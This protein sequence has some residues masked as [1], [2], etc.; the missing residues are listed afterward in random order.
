MTRPRLF[1]VDDEP[2]L[3][4]MLKFAFEEDG[5]DVAT[6]ERAEEAVAR[7]AETECD[8]VL[9][10]LRMPGMDGLAL[11]RELKRLRPE[12]PIVL[13]TAFATVDLAVGAMKEGAANFVQKPFSNL[14]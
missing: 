8:A 4:K 14:D 1:I 6:F 12:T 5:Y 13:M 11:L 9:S 2:N 10:D 7:L 3:L